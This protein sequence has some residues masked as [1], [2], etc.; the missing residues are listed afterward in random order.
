MLFI[1]FLVGKKK[2]EASFNMKMFVFD[3]LWNWSIRSGMSITLSV[4]QTIYVKSLLSA[5]KWLQRIK[6][7]KHF[8]GAVFG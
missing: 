6:Y 3:K 8:A 2:L 1:D 5:C 7:I 4:R